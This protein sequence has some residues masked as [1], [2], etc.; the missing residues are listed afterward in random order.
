MKT[1]VIIG[2]GFSGTVT[3]LEFLRLRAGEVNLVLI[4]R[5]GPMARGLAYGT[6]S[7]RHLLNVPAGNMSALTDTPDSFLQFCRIR[8]PETSPGSFMPR[9]LYGEYLQGLLQQ[10][11]DRC[12]GSARHL[13]AD[14]QRL[15]T[16]EC[17]AR[18]HLQD[19]T[20][21]DADHVVLALG[22]FAP[23]SPASLRTPS[24]AA[25][26]TV[27]PWAPAEKPVLPA[28]APLL[29]VGA[30]LTALDVLINLLQAGHRGPVYLLSRRG[31]APTTH[32]EHHHAAGTDLAWVAEALI[33]GPARVAAYLR[34]LRTAVDQHE[35]KGG[36]W[37]DVV[38]AIR[39]STSRLWQRL[40]A[41]E[42]R[43]FLRHL[44]AFWDIH[45][46]RVAPDTYKRFTEALAS[47]QARPLAGRLVDVCRDGDSLSVCIRERHSQTR[48]QLSVQ[49]VFNCTGPNSNLAKVNEPFISQLIADQMLSLDEH[50]LGVVVD[51]DLAIVDQRGISLPWLSYVGPM[52]K[53]N[54]WEATAVP[55]L[56]QYSKRLAT[57]LA[58]SL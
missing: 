40:P 32:R 13:V 30:G 7:A 21:L 35:R 2:S 23:V 29:L 26:Y 38:A 12:G 9:K 15:E 34:C 1:L 46:H 28:D 45:R 42:R 19:G 44:Q 11:L 24:L 17:G 52:L 43:R 41:S 56:R 47:G 51:D 8:H 54:W 39:P 57:R 18:I 36:D 10:Q 49:H 31:L 6:N 22:N 27:D 5:S 53:A 33:A 20:R 37:R 14:V 25:H 55:E 4:N 50:H 48:R 16:L 58:N 3:A